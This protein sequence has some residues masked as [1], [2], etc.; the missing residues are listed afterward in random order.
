MFKLKYT[1][2]ITYN[3]KLYFLHIIIFLTAFEYNSI[4]QVPD[5]IYVKKIHINLPAGKVLYAKDRYILARQDTI[6]ELPLNEDYYIANKS[7]NDKLYFELQ[8]KAYKNR[9]TKG[10]H[11][12]IIV[13]EDSTKYSEI[14]SVEKS[15]VSF[16]AY[17]NFKIRNIALNK[18]NVFG[19][20]ISK[21][22]NKARTTI[23]KYA[24]NMHVITRDGVIIDHLLFKTGDVVDPYIMADNERLL[25]SLPYIEDAKIVVKRITVISD[26]VDIE[27]ITKDNLSLGFD[28]D[29]SKN[30]NISGNIWDNN[31]FG[32]GQEFDNYFYK[33]PS[34][35]PQSGIESMYKIRNIGGSFVNCQIGYKALGAEGYSINFSRDFFTQQTKYAGDLRF[36]RN[37]TY[38]ATIDSSNKLLKW[39]PLNIENSSFWLGRAFKIPTLNLLI[40]NIN[41][42]IFSGGIFNY[43]FTSRPVIGPDFLYSFQ[44]KTYYLGNISFSSQGYFKTNLVYN[45]GKTEDIPFGTLFSYTHGYE[46]NEYGHR[47]YDG[48]SISMGNFIDNMGYLYW[49]I[50]YGGFSKKKVLEQGVLKVNASYFTNLMVIQ[51]IKTR[52]F[53]NANYV[54]GY[55]FFKDELLN[56]NN[57][58]G[59]R[60]F[61]SDSARGTHKFT[62]NFES[63]IFTPV[64]IVG[65]RFCPFVFADFA[66]IGY[67]M[68]PIFSNTMYS[69]LGFGVRIRN[70]RLVFK[71]IQLRFAFYPNKSGFKQ[72]DLFTISEETR[73]RTSNFNAHG[74]EIVRYQ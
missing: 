12:I 69:G 7:N 44:D 49:N 9:W 41:N 57:L 48:A 25:R 19:P 53:I 74:P 23:G 18:L 22:K 72:G 17:R 36:E 70:E 4:A 60:G 31:I 33:N 73:F 58:S 2:N 45:Y 46:K 29:L 50:A 71:T 24:N 54:R 8:Q 55:N 52:Y 56:I 10:L 14:L 65:F 20:S 63:V 32:S 21:P 26:S 15:E 1:P 59:I 67:T 5:S 3:I 51:S 62:I 34:Q 6:I 40:T 27:V 43:K 66:W 16:L 13:P 38:A 39:V 68:K 64:N 61:Y 11:N 30:P 35:M 47:I 42:I 28:I 37:N